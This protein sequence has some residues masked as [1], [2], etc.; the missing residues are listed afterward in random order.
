MVN[1]QENSVL[2]IAEIANTHNG[3]MERAQKLVHHV[4]LAG[5][6]VIKFQVFNAEDLVSQNHPDYQI[7]KKLEFRRNDWELLFSLAHNLGLITYADI[8]GVR[9]L[10]FLDDIGCQ[11]Y[12]I[13]SSDVNNHSLLREVGRKKRPVL[14]SLGGTSPKDTWNSANCLTQYGCSDITLMLGFQAFPTDIEDSHLRLLDW[15]KENYRLPVGYADHI[16]A[17]NPMALISPLLAVAAGANTI[18]KHITY[19]RSEKPDDYESSLEL[20]Q[21]QILVQKIRE[22]ELILGCDKEPNPSESEKRYAKK[23]KKYP[24]TVNS[25]ETGNVFQLN[26]IKYQRMMLDTEAYSANIELLNGKKVINSIPANSFIRNINFDFKIGALVAVRSG[27][28]RLPNK[29]FIQINGDMVIS[30]LINRIK[31]SSLVDTIVLCTTERPEDDGLVSLAEKSQI[32]VFRGDENDVMKRFIDA[33]RKFDID[34]IVRVTGDDIF[35]DPS[36]I[37]EALQ[38]HLEI[39]AEY[40]KMVGLPEGVDREIITTDALE[41]L[42]NH[43]KDHKMTEYMTWFLDQPAFINTTQILAQEKHNRSSYR[44]TLDTPEDLELIQWIFSELSKTGKDDYV[45]DDIISLLDANPDKA[46]S[47]TLKTSPKVRRSDIDT[48]MNLRLFNRKDFSK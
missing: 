44:L 43:A 39:N 1:K 15:Y 24:M 37:D 18:E 5:A 22:T 7:F 23:M 48:G 21:F 28:S 29:A 45:L 20:E 36:Y 47:N 32:S 27:S 19:N 40:T 3:S 13:H 17:E 34:I 31:K 10:E 16:D 4:S 12:K 42:H 2:V 41:W 46:L 6:D 11:G 9:S 8:F 33:A 14:L 35:S 38:H 30:H 26:N 25:I